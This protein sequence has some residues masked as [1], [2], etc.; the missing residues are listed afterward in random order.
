MKEISPKTEEFLLQTVRMSSLSDIV[1]CCYCENSDLCHRSIVA[2]ILMGL[3]ADIQTNAEYI[4]FFEKYLES[5][6]SLLYGLSTC[7]G[8]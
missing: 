3:G 8:V 4:R 2:G 1:L 7:A 6:R 5:K